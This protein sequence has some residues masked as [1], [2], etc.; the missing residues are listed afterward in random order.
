MDNITSKLFFCQLVY[1]EHRLDVQD[2]SLSNALTWLLGAS[3]SVPRANNREVCL[4][5][6]NVLS[7][8][9]LPVP[10]KQK[11]EDIASCFEKRA[12]FPNC[13]GAVDGK[14]IR[15]VNPVGP[16]YYNYKGYSSVLTME[17]SFKWRTRTTRFKISSRYVE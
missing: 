4:A 17:I 1:T 8:E 2:I 5:I 12:N 16:M 13:L 14:Y 10:T 6:W 7:L 11:W 15:I 9:C 3:E